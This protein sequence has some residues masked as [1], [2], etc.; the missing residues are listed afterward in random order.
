[1]TLEQRLQRI[2]YGNMPVP[3]WLAALVPVYRSLRALHRLPYR[4][5]LRKPARLPV[6]VIV[7]GNVTVGG[8]G[9]TPLVLALVDA[10]RERGWHP[11]VISR[12]YGGSNGKAAHVVT[13][14]DEAERAGDE[15][16]LIHRRSGVPV[17]IAHRRADAARLLLQHDPRIDVLIA[18][19][20]LQHLALARDIEI[21]VID[22][23]RRFG[24][25]RLLPAG[26]LREP[27]SR[28][29][30]VD[31]RICNGADAL[32]G[33]VPMRLH[34]DRIV[35]LAAPGRTL[36]LDDFRGRRVHAV[37][38]I[39]HPERFFGQLRDAGI[40]VIPHPFPDH[41]RFNAD[42]L[43]FDDD[44][45]VLM[46]EKDTVKYQRFADARHYAI[47]VDARL[48]DTFLDAVA[49]QLSSRRES[50]AADTRRLG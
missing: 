46:T 33:E 6:P 29:A 9:K 22:G 12:G 48:P 42:D 7:V 25:G 10:L 47:R 23:A 11:G 5:G 28:L 45:P 4:I 34:I 49:R 18:D 32:D 50:A 44:L 40:E 37:A 2:W 1:M 24:N 16:C 21:V 13:E 41:H 36:S 39:G 3:G 15:P 17:A 20:G 14:D 30:S 27:L 31:F 35:P 19:D 43:R 26:P 8:S 38:G